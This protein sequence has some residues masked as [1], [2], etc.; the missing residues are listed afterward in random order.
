MK[1]RQNEQSAALHAPK[2]YIAP[3]LR[4]YGRVQD[5]TAAGSRLKGG[6]AQEHSGSARARP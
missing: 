5:L 6:S 1:N 4:T 3:E 2:A